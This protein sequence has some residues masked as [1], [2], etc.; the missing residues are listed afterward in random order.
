MYLRRHCLEV[1][2]TCRSFEDVT[3]HQLEQQVY[4][5]HVSQFS[6]P[7][8]PLKCERQLTTTY[9]FNLAQEHPLQHISAVRSGHLYNMST[10]NYIK[11]VA[12]IGVR[13]VNLG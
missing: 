12:I 3:F 13:S 8:Q 7:A 2:S 4:I 6:N 10:S 5:P 9:T 11:N 1:L